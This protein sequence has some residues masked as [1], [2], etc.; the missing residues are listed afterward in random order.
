MLKLYV[1]LFLVATFGGI[2]Y[3]AYAYYTSTQSTIAI[4]RENNVKLTLANERMQETINVM[5]TDVKR[6]A[7][8]NRKLTQQLQQA[9]NNLDGLRK[10]FAEIDIEKEAQVDPDGLAVRINDAVD[11]LREELKNE[12]TPPSA[13]SNQST[14]TE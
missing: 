13:D 1:T 5:R 2:G 4:L 7:E 3:G 10:R 9:E 14:D 8:L 11:R 12:T 6:N